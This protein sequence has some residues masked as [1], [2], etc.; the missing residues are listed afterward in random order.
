M[1]P[2]AA[3]AS[4]VVHS[5]TFS[6]GQAVLQQDIGALLGPERELGWLAFPLDRSGP[7]MAFQSQVAR[8]WSRRY[9][10]RSRPSQ[11]GSAFSYFFSRTSCSSAGHWRVARPR[12]RAELPGFP[13]A[14]QGSWDV[15]PLPSWTSGLQAVVWPNAIFWAG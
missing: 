12:M 8:P 6:A 4:R 10:S 9:G 5:L 11:P 15:F 7:G 14:K 2:E 1:A 3:L 13:I